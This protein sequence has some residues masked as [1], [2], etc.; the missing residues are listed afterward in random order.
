MYDNAIKLE[1]T[2]N[3]IILKN[4]PMEFEGNQIDNIS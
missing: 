4:N 3:E 2:I 1:D